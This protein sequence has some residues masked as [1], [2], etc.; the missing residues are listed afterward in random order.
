[1]TVLNKQRVRLSALCLGPLVLET[2][3]ARDEGQDITLAASI[4][5]YYASEMCGQVADR[6]VQK[7][8]GYGYIADFPIELFY[9]DVRL[10]RF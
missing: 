3:R 5:K 4:C 1:M 6:C 7:F 10:F 9:R 8:G 2:A